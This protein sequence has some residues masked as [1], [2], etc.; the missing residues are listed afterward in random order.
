MSTNLIR[1]LALTTSIFASAAA[2]AQ[3]QPSDETKEERKRER[4]EE[5][6]R[7]RAATE[8]PASFSKASELIGLPVKAKGGEKIG[9]IRNLAINTD[10]GRIR[11][12]IVDNGS[13]TLYPMPMPAL[14]FAANR[15]AATIDTTTDRMKDAPTF[16]PEGWNTIGDTKW[17]AIVYQFYGIKKNAEDDKDRP[18]FVPAAAVMGG[19]V[20]TRKGEGL[21]SVKNIMVDTEKNVVAYAVLDF[22]RDAKLFAV[23]WQSMTV[24]D[25]GKKIVIRGVDRDDLKDSPGFANNRWPTYK[26]LNWKS[27]TNYDSRPPNWVYGMNEVGGDNAGGGSGGNGGDRGALGGWQTNGKYGQFF[28]KKAVE[29]FNGRVVRSESVTPLNGMDPGTAL[30]IKVGEKNHV[31]HLGPEWF[32]R[33]QQDKFTDGEEIEVVGSRVDIDGKAV[34]MA[35]QIRVQGRTMFL[36]NADGVP[37][38]DAWQERK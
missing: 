14:K 10:N 31:V 6:Q 21:G 28:N 15:A 23:P 16:K 33:K 11:Y 19:K 32:I 7:E 25:G 12:A 20:E 35:T 29:K 18:D 36:R 5:R 34:I 30:V 22:G 26:D 3:N 17:G 1:T 8:L 2:L 37:T 9:D 13:G 24:K 4:Q 27:D 38:W